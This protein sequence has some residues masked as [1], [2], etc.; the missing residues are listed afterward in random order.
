MEFTSYMNNCFEIDQK[1]MQL[2]QE[3]QF[4]GIRDDVCRQAVV[5]NH[6]VAPVC[7]NVLTD[8]QNFFND[9]ETYFEDFE[10]MRDNIDMILDDSKKISQ[11]FEMTK[12]MHV[13]VVKEAH[14]NGKKARAVQ[15]EITNKNAEFQKQYEVMKESV[16][17]YRKKAE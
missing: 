12:K 7:Q 15:E 16:A 6:V 8:A 14:V 1:D 5:Y 10:S 9:F 4:T 17:L 3:T 13:P 2:V 11:G